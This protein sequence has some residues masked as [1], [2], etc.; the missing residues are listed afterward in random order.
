MAPPADDFLQRIA[1]YNRPAGSDAEHRARRLC[2]G[3]LADAGLVVAERRF[4]YSSFPGLWAT[5]MIGAILMLISGWIL[6]M[7]GRGH[8]GK[9]AA[10]TAIL[11]VCATAVLAWWLGRY[12]SVSLPLLRRSGV[13][14]EA[15]R[16]VPTVWLVAHLD[17]KS[18]PVPLLVRAAGVVIT[19]VACALLLITCAGVLA[20]SVP[21]VWAATPGGVLIVGA[22]PLAFSVVHHTGGTGALDNASG[23]ATVIRAA[24]LIDPAFPFGVLVSSAEEL[25][26][27]GARGW[28]ARRTDRGIAINCDG[29]DDDGVLTCTIARDGGIFR[30]SIAAL[31]SGECR[32]SPVEVRQSVPGVLF[33]SVA[34]ADAGWPAATVSVGGV[35]SLARV[36]TRA[37][38]LDQVRGARVEP[39]ARVIAALAGSII[40]GDY[41]GDL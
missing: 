24:E 2:A 11:A 10:L 20:G 37:D 7:T 34:F 6:W 33:D 19:L 25:G 29:I 30:R 40:A 9:V 13:N 32:V 1:A 27:A 4:D 3:R 35:R 17:T 14:L 21:G 38:T 15:T 16:G 28:L 26:L 5:P 41:G 36:H 12:G 31:A 22:L 23:V 39:T 8:F 18:Q